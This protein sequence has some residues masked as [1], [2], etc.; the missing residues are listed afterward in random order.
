MSFKVILYYKYVL[1][2]DPIKAVQ[3]Q[4]ELCLR[5]GLKGRILISKEGINGTLEGTKDNIAKYVEAMNSDELFS[6]IHFKYS[7]GTGASFLKLSIKAREEIVTSGLGTEENA[8]NRIT[9]KYLKPEELK[10]WIESG[11]EFYIVDMRNDYEQKSGY[12]EGSILSNVPNFRDIPKFL[13]KIKHLKD[14]EI[15]TV[16]TGGVRC[17]KASG[18]LMQNGFENVYQLEGGIHSYMEKYP[19]EDFKGKLYVFDKRILIGFNTEDSRHEVVSSCERCGVKSENYVNCAY[20][21]CHRHYIICEECYK[22][23]GGFCNLK[24]RFVSRLA[25]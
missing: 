3:D 9:G 15:L 17:E 1:V 8:E 18:Y 25:S 4:R 23:S 24:C 12:F 13:P 5:L 11:K 16:C 14:K 6:G 22:K 19:N 7:D 21:V 20:D 10:K 2:A